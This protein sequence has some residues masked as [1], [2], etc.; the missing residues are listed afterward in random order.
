MTEKDMSPEV[1][2]ITEPPRK[3]EPGG[4]RVLGNG[5]LLETGRRNWEMLI[6]EQSSIHVPGDELPGSEPL[7]G[8]GPGGQAAGRL[9]P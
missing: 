8:P 1:G 4:V 5:A 7:L 2:Q 3:T 9:C 6:R